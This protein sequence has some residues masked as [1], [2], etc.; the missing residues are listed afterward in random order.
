MAA[1]RNPDADNWLSYFASIRTVCPWSYPAY[2][3]G[4]IDIVRGAKR[5]EPLGKFRAR[6][7][8]LNNYS[9]RRIKKIATKLENADEIHEW[10]WSHPRYGKY[11][12]PVGCLIQQSRAELAE[13]RSRYASSK[14]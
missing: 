14:S 5:I 6:V 3:Q 9:P 4:Q 8:V 10:L 13:I 11:S 7:Y 1:T 2:A 12:A